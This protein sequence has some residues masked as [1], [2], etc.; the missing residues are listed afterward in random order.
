[1][2]YGLNNKRK[3]E[4]KEHKGGALNIIGDMYDAHMRGCKKAIS[5]NPELVIMYDL[6]SGFPYTATKE[7]RD[8]FLKMWE[9]T[10]PKQTTEL[11]KG[12]F[13]VFGTGGDLNKN[14]N[15]QFEKLFYNK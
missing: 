5:E 12:K 8:S 4:T 13:F 9:E 1:M 11:Q 14:D 3:M 15:K 7:H 10:L 2:K 6:E